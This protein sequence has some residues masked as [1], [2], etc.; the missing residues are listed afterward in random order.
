MQGQGPRSMNRTRVHTRAQTV[1][2][3]VAA[4]LCF[5]AYDFSGLTEHATLSGRAFR[6]VTTPG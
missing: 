3:T 5:D 6:S 4:V 2:C 1:A